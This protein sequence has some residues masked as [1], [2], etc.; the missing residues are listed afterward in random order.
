M[1]KKLVVLPWLMKR[2]NLS[3]FIIVAAAIDENHAF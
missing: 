3:G 1:E 2:S